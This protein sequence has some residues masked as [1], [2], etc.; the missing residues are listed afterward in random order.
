MCLDP[1]Q[2]QGDAAH[3]R[4][5]EAHQVL[6]HARG[7]VV[8]LAPLRIGGLLFTR[9]RCRA[10]VKPFK[11]YGLIVLCEVSQRFVAF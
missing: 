8:L 3:Q 2:P 10:P 7:P 6:V 5:L 9:T 4:L 11:T 1:V